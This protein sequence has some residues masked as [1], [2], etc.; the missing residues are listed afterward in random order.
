[1]TGVLP[2]EGTVALKQ[3]VTVRRREPWLDSQIPTVP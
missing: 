2:D 1:M 3:S